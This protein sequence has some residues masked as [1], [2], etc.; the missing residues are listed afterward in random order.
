VKINPL[1][2]KANSLASMVKT[3]QMMTAQCMNNTA[4]SPWTNILPDHG[5]IMAY[6]TEQGNTITMS[7]HIITDILSTGID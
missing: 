3:S 4:L 7:I 5:M 1:S 2:E 6:Q